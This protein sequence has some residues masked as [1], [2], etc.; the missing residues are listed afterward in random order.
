M[1]PRRA[2]DDSTGLPTRDQILAFMQDHPGKVGK[3][4]IARAFNVRS[5]D[6]IALKKLLKEMTDDGLLERRRK[7]VARPGH[8]APVEVLEIVGRDDDGELIAA[9][10]DWD[11]EA[12]GAPP[13]VVVMPERGKRGLRAPGEGDRVLM[14]ISEAEH[15]GDGPAFEGR[16]IRVLESRPKRM[17]G[18]FARRADGSAVVH[19]ADK[20]DRRDYIVAAGDEGGAKDGDLVS[21]DIQRGSRFGPAKVKVRERVGDMKSEKA[22]SMI[23]I[24]THG[25]PHAFPDS[26]I[27]EAEAA[28]PATLK[29][30]LDLRKLPLITI[31]P[32]DAKDHDDAV[33]AA[34]DA[35]P[36]NPGG[37]VVTVAIAD[38][39]FYVRPGGALDRAARERGNSVYF[40]DRVVPM[41]PERLSTDLCSLKAGEDRPAMVVEMKIAAD[42]RKLK[43]RFFRAMMRSAA[44][45]SY[46]RA[47][48]AADGRPDDE[49][50]PLTDTVIRPLWDAYA[51]VAKARD[52]REP[53]ELD[54]P[55]RKLVLDGTGHVE[56]VLVPERLEA[57]RLIEAFMILANVAAAETLEEKRTPLLYRVHDSPSQEKLA[58]LSDF[59]QTIDMKMPK[60][61]ITLPRHFNG[62]LAQVRDT[63]N[64]RILNEVVLRSQAQAE[65][66]PENFGHFGLNL[67]RY[68][69][70][71]SPIRRYS[72][73]VVHRALIRAFDLGK[74]GLA[75]RQIEELEETAAHISATERR[76]MAAERE[77]V[78]RLIA[79]FLAD[80]IGA[81]FH[82]RVAG[83]TRSGL[84]V[85]LDD[86]GAD[87]F[88]PAATIG[89]DYF[90]HDE[91]GQ[92]L[93]GDR[94][95]EAYRLGDP[96]EVKL[97][98]AVPLAGALRFEIVSEGRYI[99]V[100][101]AARTRRPAPAKRGGKTRRQARRK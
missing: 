88:V 20:K 35:D 95:G 86:T 37:F 66:S 46:S 36:E 75:D 10:T 90:R 79:N 38:V 74:D 63:E 30:R 47:Q 72:D 81:T 2:P 101:K 64:E 65:Y 56:K 6:R 29:G 1:S 82:G 80:R 41:L 70:F 15:P 87:G 57:H 53:L 77:T 33:H 62:I 69:H 73:L 59:L 92:Q 100:R 61:G 94:T 21:A 12:H 84:F 31:D 98:E 76:A 39:A 97:V 25:I 43:H 48:A 58:S 96:V 19:S 78:D 13:R 5:G 22:V 67:R 71:T 85:K 50:R 68:A 23:A 42:G 3:R 18:V 11:E 45:L 60:A 44:G 14:R 26:A 16:V 17:I 24:L 49:A 28:Q 93:V 55:E 32:A 8:F 40:P 4:E 9:P 27:E 54:I 91:A 51:A 89:D 7:R 83:V 52:A 99:S 34:P